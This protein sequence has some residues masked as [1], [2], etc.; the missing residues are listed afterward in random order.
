L[1]AEYEKLTE[2]EV[3][4][5]AKESKEPWFEGLGTNLAH[6]KAKADKDAAYV[7]REAGGLAKDEVTAEEYYTGNKEN[8]SDD[9]PGE[10]ILNEGDEAPPDRD[11]AIRMLEWTVDLLFSTGK[12]ELRHMYASVAIPLLKGC[13]DKG[14][15]KEIADHFG[16]SDKRIDQII[17]DVK[18]FCKKD[19]GDKEL[20]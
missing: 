7:A 10:E 4:A 12:D 5:L 16:K 3:K 15:K 9:D 13:L 17:H 18:N 19:L 14:T 11:P 20:S 8:D 1:R 2:E 6:V